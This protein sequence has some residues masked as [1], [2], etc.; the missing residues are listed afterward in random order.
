MKATSIAIFAGL[1][2]GASWAGVAGFYLWLTRCHRQVRNPVVI[3][4]GYIVIG[5]VS[6]G[7]L[8]LLRSICCSLGIVRP[9]SSYYAAL[10]SYVAGG[11]FVVFPAIRAEA[12]WRKSVDLDDKSLLS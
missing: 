3:W 1:L 9:N 2:L 10:Y 7:S 12:H 8:L 4:L 6:L 11:A 5:A